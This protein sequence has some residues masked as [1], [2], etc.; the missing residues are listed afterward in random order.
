MT[1][2]QF[3]MLAKS[4]DQSARSALLES[5]T[6]FIREKALEIW[7]GNKG[8]MAFLGTEVE[9]LEQEGAIGLLQC[10]DRFDEKKKIK[11]L[12]YAGKAIRNAMLD[13]IGE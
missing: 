6:A 1:N 12:T 11:F 4:G 2:E 10:I 5:N 7:N 3:C 13:M 9:D 8:I